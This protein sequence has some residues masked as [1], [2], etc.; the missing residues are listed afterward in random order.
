ML[1]CLILSIRKTEKTQFHAFL[2]PM[3]NS[4]VYLVHQLK[5]KRTLLI[6]SIDTNTILEPTYEGS[7]YGVQQ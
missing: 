1:K 6:C 3:L 5:K 2:A 7:P 4:K